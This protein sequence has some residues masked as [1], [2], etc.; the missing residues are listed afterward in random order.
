MLAAVLAS[1]L[2]GPAKAQLIQ[3]TGNEFWTGE[4]FILPLKLCSPIK[5]QQ[6]ADY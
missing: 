1:A 3:T 2:P 6:F 5:L 4:A